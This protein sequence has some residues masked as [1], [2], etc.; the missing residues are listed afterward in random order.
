MNEVVK[1]KQ[2]PEYV[3]FL[4]EFI[5]GHEEA[6]IREAFK[7]KF[8]I[9]LTKY[10]VKN[11]KNAYKV[12]SGTHGG[13]FQK[14]QESWNKGRKMTKEQYKKAEPTM[15]K[16]GQIPLNKREV[17]SERT[18]RDGY[19]LVKVA[20]PNKWRLK[21]RVMYEEYHNDKLTPNDVI[22]FLDNNREN[23]AQ[24][25]LVKLTRAELARYNQDNLKTDNP[26]YNM[27][28]VILAKLKT[29]TGGA[30]HGTNTRTDVDV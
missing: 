1:W 13:R 2:H 11:F 19:V 21:Q 16:K 8:G 20:E 28:A 27:T 12:K 22:V 29:K 30:K 10:K 4:R 23:F 9:E 25:N 15:F 6:E 7:E 26:D 5:P 14:G 3:E 17:G 18:D 24:E